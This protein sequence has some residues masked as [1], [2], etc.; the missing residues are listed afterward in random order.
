MQ[1]LRDDSDSEA[2]TFGADK[3]YEPEMFQDHCFPDYYQPHE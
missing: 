1:S 3:E 2:E